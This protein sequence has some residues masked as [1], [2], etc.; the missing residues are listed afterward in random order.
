MQVTNVREEIYQHLMHYT[1]KTKISN[2]VWYLIMSSSNC[3]LNLRVKNTEMGG[4]CVV[5]QTM[6]YFYN[7]KSLRRVIISLP[8]QHLLIVSSNIYTCTES[9]E[10]NPNK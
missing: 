5:K 1:V 8:S 6:F 4:H 9:K 10:I 3:I 7:G 2:D